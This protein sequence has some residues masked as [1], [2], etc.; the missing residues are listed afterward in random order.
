MG[1]Q[2]ARITFFQHFSSLLFLA[3]QQG[4]GEAAMIIAVPIPKRLGVLQETDEE[5][6]GF[7]K[8]RVLRAAGL[9]PFLLMPYEQLP[10]P[11]L[12]AQ[13]TMRQRLITGQFR[14]VHV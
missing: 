4:E 12:M 11:G 14:Q 6:R 9:P 10:R 7:I 3:W 2:I 1:I 8:A 5:G 13:L